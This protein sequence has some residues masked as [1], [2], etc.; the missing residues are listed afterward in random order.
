[1]TIPP[2]CKRPFTF[3]LPEA[4]LPYFCHPTVAPFTSPVR[5]PSGPMAA[6]SGWVA[7]TVRRFHG[8]PEE[9]PEASTAFVERFGSLPWHRFE[10]L[11]TREE[12]RLFDTVSGTLW[13]DPPL[14]LWHPAPATPRRPSQALPLITDHRSPGTSPRI[15][16]D[17]L[18]RIHGGPLVPLALLQLISRLPRAEIFLDP[19]LTPTS[20]LFF[21]FSGDGLGIIPHHRHLTGARFELFK[22]KQAS[23]LI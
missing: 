6:A 7:L 13:R 4:A 23:P 10:T 17:K 9:Y 3:P 2:P 15:S 18:V 11:A 5:L 22:P 8:F 1:M 21:R 20:P 19:H 14:P 12:W 16:S